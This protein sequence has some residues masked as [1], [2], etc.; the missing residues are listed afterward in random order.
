MTQTMQNETTT[1][2]E[3]EARAV[4]YLVRGFNSA[5]LADKTPQQVRDEFDAAFG[6]LC[7]KTPP[8]VDQV[9]HHTLTAGDG[10]EIGLRLYRPDSAAPLPVILFFHAGGYIMGNLDLTDNFCRMM[11]QDGNC[12]VAS[13]D[14]RLA[15]ECKFPGPLEDGYAALQWVA[16]HA[17]SLGLDGSRIATA[18]ESSGGTLAIGVCRL[19]IARGGPAVAKVFLWYPGTG[20]VGETES[21]RRYEGY[22]LDT[23]LMRHSIMSYVNDQSDIAN[24]LVQPIRAED[25]DKM[26]PVYL[27]SAGLDPR[28]DDNEIYANML[29][30]AGVDVEYHSVDGTLHGFL[31][32]LR[33]H[34]LGL[35]AA[36]RSVEAIARWTAG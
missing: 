21:A 13:V 4:L 34:P 11:A 26:P 6:S 14:Y 22:V 3:T 10:V 12:A 30:E 17:A 19:A 29:R 18:G 33:E 9:S 25:K 31:F 27:M 23:P 28:H 2:D 1:Q 32:M 24:P 20:S 7:L 15:P 16:A 5:E 8:P 36:K 35:T